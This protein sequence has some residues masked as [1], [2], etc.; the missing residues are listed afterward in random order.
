MEETDWSAHVALTCRPSPL[1]VDLGS[2]VQVSASD[3]TTACLPLTLGEFGSGTTAPD[4]HNSES[5]SNP[6]P[7]SALRLKA[8][9]QRRRTHLSEQAVHSK[10][11]KTWS[12]HCWSPD[13][14]PQQTGALRGLCPKRGQSPEGKP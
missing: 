8:N 10:G 12:E 3:L 11:A 9:A 6:Q 5:V 4:P 7:K 1:H 14:G 13:D 2:K